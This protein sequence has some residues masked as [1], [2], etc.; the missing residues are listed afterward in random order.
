MS[1]MGYLYTRNIVD[2]VLLFI[3]T[4]FKVFINFKI[5]NNSIVDFLRKAADDIEANTADICTLTES[6][7]FY[8]KI[9]KP[10]IVLDEKTI[11]K[12]MYL[13]W[14]LYSNLNQQNEI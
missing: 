3:N 9:N 8:T 1:G 10:D 5:M 14:Y 4:L 2:I 12:Y 13:G 6:I 7:Y 11:M